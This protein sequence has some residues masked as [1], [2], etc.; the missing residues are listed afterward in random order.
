M[1]RHRRGC[2]L[3]CMYACACTAR[4]RRPMCVCMHVCK[5]MCLC[6]RMCARVY[7]SVHMRGNASAHDTVYSHS[8]GH[9]C[10]KPCCPSKDRSKPCSAHPSWQHHTTLIPLGRATQRQSPFAAQRPSL[11]CSTMQRPSPLASTTPCPH[12]P[13]YAV[14][15]D[16]WCREPTPTPCC[17]LAGIR[18]KGC[19]AHDVVVLPFV[20]LVA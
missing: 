11:L 2:L 1:H 19:G 8:D 7:S 13:E 12:P 14:Q 4:T 10:R 6:V 18:G 20:Q 16:L 17:Q 15:R 9:A 3:V 5:C